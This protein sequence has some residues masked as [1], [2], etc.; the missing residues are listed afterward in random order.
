MY[1][2][3]ISMW[4]RWIKIYAKLIYDIYV[5]QLS[6]LIMQSSLITQSKYDI[7]KY[8]KYSFSY[9]LFLRKNLNLTL[10]LFHR[11]TLWVDSFRHSLCSY[12]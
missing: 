6:L 5:S 9:F 4:A 2:S 12:F 7:S 10:L 3:I 8:D 1:K 11:I